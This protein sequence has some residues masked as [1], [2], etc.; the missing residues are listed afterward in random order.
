MNY[1]CAAGNCPGCLSRWQRRVDR[2]RR[3]VERE[4]RR[5]WLGNTLWSSE[6]QNAVVDDIVKDYP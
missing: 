2:A 4:D 3:L 5:V 1:C 6:K